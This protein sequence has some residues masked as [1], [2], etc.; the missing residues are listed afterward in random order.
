MDI[1]LLNTFHFLKAAD[2][3]SNLIGVVSTAI[4]IFWVLGTIF[5][6]CEFGEKMTN[7]FEMFGE[8]LERCDWLLLSIEMRE[9]YLIFLLDTQQPKTIHGYG[10]IVCSRDTYK[11]VLHSIK[12]ESIDFSR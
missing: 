11:K 10:G 8:E 4:L 2:D 7:Q 5:I 3:N 12:I 1:Y 9:V 6:D